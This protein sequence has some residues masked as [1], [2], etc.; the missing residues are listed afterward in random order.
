MGKSRSPDLE[1]VWFVRTVGNQIDTEFTFWM[2]NCR[3]RLTSRHMKALSKQLEVMDHG[4]HVTLHLLTQRRRNL[5]I[6]GNNRT[7]VLTQPIHA[8][9]NDAVGLAHLLYTHQISV[10]AITVDA[11][12]DIEIQLIIHSVGLLLTQ[13]PGNA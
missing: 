8:L 11:D 12:R 7:W 3:I 5:V 6:V 2:L 9:F 1:T 4:L 13:I 10:I